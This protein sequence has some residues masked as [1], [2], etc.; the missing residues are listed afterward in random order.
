MLGF[1]NILT[2]AGHF[3]LSP[4][5]REKTDRRDSR[6]EREGQGR[7][8]KINE[9]EETEKISTFPLKLYCCKDSRPYPTVSQSQLQG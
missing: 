9:S 7:K 2:L 1:T 8:R 6:N 4:R 5:E 3:V